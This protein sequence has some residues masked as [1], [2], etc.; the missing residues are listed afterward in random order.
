MNCFKIIPTQE[1]NH[2]PLI[3][4]KLTTQLYSFYAKY[5]LPKPT[6]IY[7]SIYTVV[8]ELLVKLMIT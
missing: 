6:E 3:M 5:H 4:N 2:A 8:E 7:I 1:D